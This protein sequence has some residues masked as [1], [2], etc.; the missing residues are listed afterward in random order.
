MGQELFI[1]ATLFGGFRVTTEWYIGT[2]PPIV[3]LHEGNGTRHFQ[4][5]CNVSE[6]GLLSVT[7]N[8]TNDVSQASNFTTI[9]YLYAVNGFN[10][11]HGIYS[12]LEEAN[13]S[14]TLDASADLPMGLIT[15][16]TDFGDG[17]TNLSV[18]NGSDSSFITT[19]LHFIHHY[20]DASNY[21]TVITLTSEINSINLR[22]G[23]KILEPIFGIEVTI[24]YN[25]I[26]YEFYR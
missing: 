4:V 21:S 22:T 17:N 14:L 16:V 8:A 26:F 7:V 6:I 20:V 13:V 3:I 10:V 18:I 15:I 19:G 24:R 5:R 9:Y 1:N 12:T 23:I 2:A 11:S 25:Y